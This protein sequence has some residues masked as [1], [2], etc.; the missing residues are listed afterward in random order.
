MVVNN[1]YKVYDLPMK[2]VNVVV[3]FGSVSKAAKALTVTRVTIY[4]W[5]RQGVPKLR[6]IQIEK[7][8]GGALKADPDS[9][10]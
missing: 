10:A 9:V 5:L 3:H 1:I 8:S 2:A 6:Q 4:N 7:V